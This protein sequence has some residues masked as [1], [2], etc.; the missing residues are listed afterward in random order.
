MCVKM[1]V[2][3]EFRELLSV[4]IFGDRVSLAWDLPIGRADHQAP[5]TVPPQHR[6]YKCMQLFLAS[7]CGFWSSC[8][9]L[10]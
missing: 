2:H 9:V 5:G 10:H 6:V 7:L 8:Q 1:Q 4:V 3:L